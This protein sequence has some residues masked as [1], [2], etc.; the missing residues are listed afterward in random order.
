MGGATMGGTMILGA[1][2]R[3]GDQ[4]QEALAK[5][6]EQLD[7]DGNRADYFSGSRR[8]NA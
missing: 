7:R 2:G 4:A 5:K 1:K 6:I 8:L 3:Y